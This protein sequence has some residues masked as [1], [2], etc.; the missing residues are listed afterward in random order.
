MGLPSVKIALLTRLGQ[1]SIFD[2]PFCIRLAFAS[3][4]ENTLV[5]PHQMNLQPIKATM[6]SR[7]RFK[8]TMD[9]GKPDR[10]PYFEE[11]I[12]QDVLR[13]WRMQGL[14]RDTDLAKMFPSDQ[15][16][17]MQV[18]LEPRP[19][20]LARRDKITN[21]K[22][23]SRRLN[24]SD[25]K[26]LP[27]RW[28]RRIRAWQ[29]REHV[30][31]LY[32]HRGFFLTMGVG[33]W[34]SFMAAMT[35]LTD[36]PD[37]VRQRMKIQGEFAARLTDRILQEVEIDA[38]VFS[39]PIGG[40]DRPLIS[41]KMY[42]EF[43]LKNYEPILDVLRRH[44]V[45]TICMQTFAN[46]RILIPSI[47]KW[48]FNCL[49]ACEVNIDAMDYRNLRKEFGR[50]LRLIGGIDLDALR[51]DKAAIQQEIEEKVPPLIED[52]GYIPLADGRVRAD[53]PFENYAYYRRLLKEVT[54]RQ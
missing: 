7:Q 3:D 28:P 39:E 19:R 40:N 14:A 30:L 36:Q 51:K 41:P 9:Y 29:T 13:A 52:G 18:D 37:I 10:V 38:V 27:N 49:W 47:L 17:R 26:R 44:E 5:L 42:A 45:A 34:E 15:R 23:F 48:G 20:V 6:S 46:A 33:D 16:E 50:D 11:G 54:Q 4:E 1:A 25:K 8:E 22:K 31:M 21:L 32:V 35:L 2:R 24:P 43:V 53:V 12:R